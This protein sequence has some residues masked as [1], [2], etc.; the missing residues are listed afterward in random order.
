MWHRGVV[1]SS[2]DADCCFVHFVERRSV[3]LVWHDGLRSVP[4]SPSNLS[5]QPS[6]ASSSS[7]SVISNLVRGPRR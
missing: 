6:R 7:S 4:P 3:E 5:G 1:H 2:V